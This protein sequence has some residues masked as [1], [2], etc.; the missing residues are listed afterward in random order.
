MYL[1]FLI[2]AGDPKRAVTSLAAFRSE[3]L[4]W[5]APRRS[6]HQPLVLVDPIH[7]DDGPAGSMELDMH[8]DLLIHADGLRMMVEVPHIG[9][10][11]NR[12]GEGHPTHLEVE[13]QI[14]TNGAGRDS[15]VIDLRPVLLIMSVWEG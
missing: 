12:E 10:L 1:H 15:M 14:G 9:H 13:Y 11:A 5:L 2:T 7:F 4:A 8:L 3:R 6:Q